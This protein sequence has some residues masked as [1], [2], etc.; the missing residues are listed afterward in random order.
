MHKEVKDSTKKQLMIVHR[1]DDEGDMI[2]GLGD[3]SKGKF[4]TLHH[5]HLAGER[6]A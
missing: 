4:A 2:S 3:G 5:Q 6:Q 1:R